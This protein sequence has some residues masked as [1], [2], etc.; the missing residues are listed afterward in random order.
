LSLIKKD[1]LTNDRQSFSVTKYSRLKHLNLIKTHKDYQEE[2]L[3]DMKT[4]LPN[5]IHVQ[6]DYRLTRKVIRNFRRNTTRN[7]YAQIHDVYFSQKQT[8]PQHLTDYFP[9]AK[10]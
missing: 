5:G 7:N 2:F 6:M 8:F 4:S 10:I 9:F 1:K 3:S